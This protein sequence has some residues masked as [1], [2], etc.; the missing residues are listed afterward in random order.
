[1]NLLRRP[2]G[3]VRPRK[4]VGRGQGSGL[5]CTSGRGNNGQN[6]RSGGGV[7][8]GFEGGQMPLYRRVARRGFSNHPFKKDVMIFNLDIIN[9]TYKTNE[10]VSVQTLTDKGLLSPRRT[11]DKIKILSNGEI[12][13]K[14]TVHESIAI[15]SSAEEKILQ[16]GGSVLGKSLSEKQDAAAAETEVK[17]KDIGEEKNGK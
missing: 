5:G 12:K 15:S 14:I 3:S 16:A 1:M 17:V 13:K 7:R 9:S 8:P 4:R 10:T 6:S 2:E 11:V